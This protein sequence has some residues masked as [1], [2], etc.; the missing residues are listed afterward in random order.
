M[1]ELTGKG[2][3]ITGASG[4]IGG[5]IARALHRQGAAVALSGTRE[6]ALDALKAELGERATS[7]PCDLA[8]PQ[9]QQRVAM[10][11]AGAS[12][13]LQREDLPAFR[14]RGAVDG[15]QDVTGPHAGPI[16]R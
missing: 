1:F 9:P 14:H 2:A 7:L 6:D 4:G 12:P 15:E 5:E 10:A 11:V 13:H 16:S 8:R 3:L